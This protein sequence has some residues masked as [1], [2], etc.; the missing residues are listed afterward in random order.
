MMPDLKAVREAIDRAQEATGPDR[1]LDRALMALF[2]VRDRRHIGAYQTGGPPGTNGPCMDDV[3]VDPRTDRWVTTAKDGFEFSRSLDEAL[4][5]V[6]LAFPGCVWTVSNSD[7]HGNALARIRLTPLFSVEEN[8]A[9]PALSVIYAVLQ[10]L[11]REA[12][13]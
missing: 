2:Y 11:A 12:R 8:E 10:G 13:T 9:T 3:W 1:N 4:R 5:L 6:V 7:G